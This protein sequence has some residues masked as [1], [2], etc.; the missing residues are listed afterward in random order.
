MR[1]ILIV[2]LSLILSSVAFADDGDAKLK[3][4]INGAGND[5]QNFI[6]VSNAGCVSMYYGNHGEVYHINSGEVANI[7]TANVSSLKLTVQKL[8]ESCD[9]IKVEKAQTL[10]VTGTLEHGTNNTTHITHM[11][12]S[13]A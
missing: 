8:P 5:N 2:V 12:C 6:C 11:H 7:L 10:T 1:A 4:K 3:I 13:I 9:H